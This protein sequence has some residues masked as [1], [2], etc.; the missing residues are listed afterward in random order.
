MLLGFSSEYKKSY[1]GSSMDL[2]AKAVKGALDMAKLEPKDIDGVITSWLPW[3]FDGA[4]AIGFPENYI[5]EYLGI[6][7]RFVD[8]VQ[9]GGAS[10]IE[11]FYRAYKAVKSGE[12][13]RVLCVIGGKGTIMKKQLREGGINDY[14]E[15]EMN[16][17]VRNTPFDELIRVYK[18]MDPIS[19]YAMVAKRHSKLFGTTDEQRALLAV[20]QRYNANYNDRALFRGPL[21]VKDVINSRIVSSPLHLFEITYPIDGFLAFIVGKGTSQLRSLEVLSYGDAI[22]PEFVAERNIDIVYT[23]TIESVKKINFNLNKIDAF[24]IY[25]A[26]TIMVLTELED[27]GL[28]EKGKIGKFVEENDLTIKGNIPVNTGGGSLNM[29]QPA[30][31]SGIIIL[32]EAFLQFN[33][34]AKGHQVGGADYILINGLGGWNT[35]A[36]TLIIGERK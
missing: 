19:F 1:E 12:A 22:W 26:F 23:P 28:T 33:N 3:I 31:M 36:S 13:D 17:I 7:P 14:L 11:M 16:N 24:E 5:S 10:A 30:Y 9:Y 20:Q 21:T 6:K 25:D 4:L 15:V 29:G 27:L 18:D 34:L 2:M 8:L 35:H 32:E